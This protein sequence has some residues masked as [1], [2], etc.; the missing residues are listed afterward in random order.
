MI[1]QGCA[2]APAAGG[3]APLPDPKIWFEPVSLLQQHQA[4]LDFP[5]NYNFADIRSLRNIPFIQRGILTGAPCENEITRFNA[6]LCTQQ[7]NAP[8]PRTDFH[9][10]ARGSNQ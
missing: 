8:G 10:T 5:M 7:F 9:S 4:R 3:D 1:H 6:L 2:A